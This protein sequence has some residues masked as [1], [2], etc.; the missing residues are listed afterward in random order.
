MTKQSHIE[1][2]ALVFELN[3]TFLSILQAIDFSKFGGDYSDFYSFC[4]ILL[5]LTEN[6]RERFI[7]D[8]C[9]L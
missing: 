8:G 7:K 6:E 3:T 9:K 1:S 4:Q 2:T 5:K